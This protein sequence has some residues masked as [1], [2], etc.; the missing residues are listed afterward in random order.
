MNLANLKLEKMKFPKNIKTKMED[1]VWESNDYEPFVISISDVLQN[2]KEILSYSLEFSPTDELFHVINKKL[3]QHKFIADGHGWADFILK[4]LQKNK[5]QFTD[6]IHNDSESET[7]ALCASNE[8]DFKLLLQHISV[9]F[10]SLL[11]D[12][13]DKKEDT[14]RTVSIGRFW[15]QTDEED[16]VEKPEIL[17]KRPRIDYRVS[18]YIWN[19]IDSN[20]L[21]PK[22]AFQKNSLEITL[23]MEPI[24]KNQKF[25]YGSVYDTDFQKFHPSCKGNKLKYVTI[26]CRYDGFNELMSP[27]DYAKVI[28]DMYCAFVVD[29]FKKI[30]KEE[31]DDL[32]TKIDFNIV[33]SF[34]FPAR[35]DNQ[36]YSG[37]GGGYGGRS[38]NFVPDPNA[39][40]YNYRTVY[41]EHYE[42][43]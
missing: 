27:E 1:G 28:F 13:T 24:N 25:F 33:N 10:Q 29:N 38:I 18:E 39:V 23:S 3:E 22:K 32:K 36:K 5:V 30:T 7:C 37:D 9:Y 4:E 35:F 16:D 40:P 21:A 31:C 12:K 8:I 6:Q 42:Q 43:K 26:S 2:G 34:E 19:F 20:L 11:K 15:S 14:E 17:F 41:L